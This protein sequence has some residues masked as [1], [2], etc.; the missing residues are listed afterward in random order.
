AAAKGDRDEL[1]RVKQG[2]LAVRYAFLACWS[3]LRRECLGAG[4]TWPLP[5]SRK[6]VAEE[7]L[8][9]ATNPGPEGWTPM[10]FSN[11]RGQTPQAFFEIVKT[12]VSDPMGTIALGTGTASLL[13][14]DMTDPAD[15]VV[16]RGS[17]AGDD[18]EAK[19][20][21]LK[22]TWVDMKCFPANP[23]GEPAHQRHPYQSWQDFPA[24]S[25][26][27]NKPEQRKWYVGFKDGG[28][29][30]PTSEKPYF[31]A[32]KFAKPFVLTHFTITTAGD[33]PDRDPRSWS[34]QA[35][36]T[37]KDDDWTD[38]LVCNADSRD[39]SP[40]RET[41]RC[42]TSLFTSF[43]SADMKQ[44]VSPDDAKKIE[45]KLKG[46]KIGVAHFTRPAKPYAWYRIAITACFNGNGMD[47]ANA[48]RPPGFALGQVEFFGVP[49]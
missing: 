8:A 40:L 46:Q 7:W 10:T 15:A 38:V 23:P 42:E 37:G 17:Y 22:S 45:A 24:C 3:Q 25:I 30:G 19:L 2:H 1:W 49:K 18:S 48:A 16:D 44:V 26:F 11:E 39:S 27:L 14:G 9:E 29:G 41:P 31:V 20:R 36:N 28:Y 43:T 34:I 35:S 33:M 12:D 21:P 4:E 47:V 5:L 6:A 32:V 13:G